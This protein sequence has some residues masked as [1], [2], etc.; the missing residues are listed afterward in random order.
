MP[1]FA[2][3][4]PTTPA[5]GR[6][7]PSWRKLKALA[8]GPLGGSWV[9]VAIAALFAA[10]REHLPFGLS[11]EVAPLALQLSVAG[12][13]FGL[14]GGGLFGVFCPAEIKH[15]K[16]DDDFVATQMPILENSKVDEQV[17]TILPHVSSFSEARKQQ[18]RDIL[19]RRVE[20]KSTEQDET[21]LEDFRQKYFRT[22]AQQYLYKVVERANV[23]A[24][25][26]RQLIVALF[27]VG[28]CLEFGVLGY[29]LL[30]FFGVI[31]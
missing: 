17:N 25:G 31:K 28:G 15:S 18:I 26:V 22:A 27:A 20:G 30:Q 9:L 5:A 8:K 7:P 2:T 6:W 23:S 1:S 4:P 16:L 24:P 14:L 3:T 12:T 10:A 19:A 13:L 21:V 29:R 11:A